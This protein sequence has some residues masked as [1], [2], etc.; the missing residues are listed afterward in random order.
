MKPDRFFYTAAGSI[1]LVLII[2]GF[3][4]YMFGGKHADG[5]PIAPS[6]LLT[7]VAHSTAIFAWFVLFFVQSLLI[8]TRNRKLH[9]KLGWSVL[10]IASTIAVTGPIVATRSIRLDPAPLF[11][12]PGNQF[13]FIMY[14]EIALFVLFVTIGVLNRKRPS[15]HRPMMLMASMVILTGAT[16]RIPLFHSVFGLHHWTAL[17]GPVV[18]LGALLLLVRVVMTRTF[19]RQFAAAY[20]ALIVATVVAAKLA[21]TNAWINWAGMILKL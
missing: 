12:W 9:M 6:I 8:S 7:V 11:D 4:R 17:F 10:L 2:I 19:D 14:S 1:F 18:A 21:E 13:L 3:Q 20:A 5:S 16:G 15:I